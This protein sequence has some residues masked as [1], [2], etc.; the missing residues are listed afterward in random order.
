M[1]RTVIAN[2]AI[3][4]TEKNGEQTQAAN[5]TLSTGMGSRQYEKEIFG[6]NKKITSMQHFTKY[7]LTFCVLA[8]IQG[9]CCMYLQRGITDKASFQL[10]VRI[11]G[12]YGMLVSSWSLKSRQLA[13]GHLEAN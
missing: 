11:K 9:E 6:S 13:Q 7:H 4:S 8:R 10:S 3:I 2:L 1:M 12:N 5:Q